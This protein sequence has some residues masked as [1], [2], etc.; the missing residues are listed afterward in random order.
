MRINGVVFSH[1]EG[2]IFLSRSANRAIIQFGTGI[3]WKTKSVEGL[4]LG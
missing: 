1:A 2:Y 3:S 4:G